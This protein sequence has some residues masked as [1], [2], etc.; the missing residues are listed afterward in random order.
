MLP[1]GRCVPMCH[2]SMEPCC[3]WAGDKPSVTVSWVSGLE[4]E[5]CPSPCVAVRS[6]PSGSFT[7]CKHGSGPING[8]RHVSGPGFILNV[9]TTEL[10]HL[11]S[12]VRSMRAAGLVLTDISLSPGRCHSLPEERAGRLLLCGRVIN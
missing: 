8:Q 5:G 12:W 11:L 10:R 2:Q 4:V 7:Q 3:R 6:Q 9:T 1:G